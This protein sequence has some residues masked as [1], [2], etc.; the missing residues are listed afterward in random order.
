[1]LTLSNILRPKT[2]EDFIGQKHIVSHET[3]FYKLL[4]K[5]VLPHS[6]FLELQ[7]QGKQ[8]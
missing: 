6:F 3:F 7:E 8:H 1:M 5:K 4:K 2:I